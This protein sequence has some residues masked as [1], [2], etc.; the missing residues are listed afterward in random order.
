MHVEARLAEMG[1]T[2]PAEMRVPPGLRIKWRQVRVIGARAVIA[3]HGPR[4]ADGTF[5]GKPGKVGAD[6]TVEEGYAAAR[7]TALLQSVKWVHL[8]PL[9]GVVCKNGISPL[10]ENNC[11]PQLLCIQMGCNGRRGRRILLGCGFG[12][13]RGKLVH[14]HRRASVF[15]SASTRLHRTSAGLL[16]TAPSRVLPS[17]AAGVLPS[18]TCVLR[19][20]A[21]L[22]RTRIQ[23]RL[24]PSA[25]RASGLGRPRRLRL[26]LPAPH[27]GAAEL[28]A[29][30]WH[31]P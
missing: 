18:C 4:Q 16:R 13:C 6:L 8:L 9:C 17:A 31:S 5:A 20:S 22:L 30:G 23:G 15:R 14:R 24:S 1:L 7:D 3:G 21:G 12:Q 26:T 10:W 11:E 27:A 28:N 19:T 25:S 2:L 29:T